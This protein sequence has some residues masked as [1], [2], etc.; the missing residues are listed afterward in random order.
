MVGDEGLEDRG[1]ELGLDRWEN[2]VVEVAWVVVLVVVTVD[3]AVVD[4]ESLLLVFVDDK[5]FGVGMVLNIKD[6]VFSEKIV[7]LEG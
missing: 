7:D 4:V 5:G 2:G 1:R 3:G 6:R